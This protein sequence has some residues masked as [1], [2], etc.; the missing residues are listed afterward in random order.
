MQAMDPRGHS[1]TY[2]DKKHIAG[3]QNK[4]F[5]CGRTYLAHHEARDT[6]APADVCQLCRNTMDI[7]TAW[8][9]N[10]QAHTTSV[11]FNQKVE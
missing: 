7:M 8:H 9:L 6:E 2:N 10:A 4:L 11:H 5:L 1:V 3:F